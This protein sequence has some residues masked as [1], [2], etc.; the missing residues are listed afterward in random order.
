MYVSKNCPLTAAARPV[1]A[2]LMLLRPV[3]EAYISAGASS[4]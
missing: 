2:R 1:D 3:E 4:M